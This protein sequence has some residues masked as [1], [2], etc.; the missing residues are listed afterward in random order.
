MSRSVLLCGKIQYKGITVYNLSRINVYRNTCISETTIISV[1]CKSALAICCPCNLTIC[2]NRSGESSLLRS[3]ASISQIS[4]IIVTNAH[5]LNITTSSTNLLSRTS[6]VYIVKLTVDLLSAISHCTA[7]EHYSTIEVGISDLIKL[8]VELVELKL[9]SVTV[10][11]VLVC[12]V[13][14][15]GSELLHSLQNGVG[16]LSSALKCLN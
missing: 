6:G 4:I 1:G 12:T 9:D 8:I 3:N 5:A 13:S 15:L 2:I 7:V 10:N 11:L 16:L 14:R